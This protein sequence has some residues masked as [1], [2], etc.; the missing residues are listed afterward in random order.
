MKIKKLFK[1]GLF[2]S[3]SLVSL[4]FYGVLIGVL[5]ARKLGS[6][7]FGLY[8]VAL[9][10]LVF[11]GNTISNSLYLTLSN[12]LARKDTNKKRGLTAP[13]LLVLMYSLLSCLILIND[14]ISFL[15]LG[16]SD[17][18]FTASFTFA[19][20]SILLW[21]IM[22]AEH[23]TSGRLK[24][25]SLVNLAVVL[26]S[27]SVTFIY[28]ND[29]NYA[30]F[31]WGTPYFITSIIFIITSN[32]RVFDNFLNP[33]IFS[34]IFIIIK[35]TFPVIISSVIVPFTFYI[36]YI[37]VSKQENGMQTVALFASTMQ[38]TWIFS[39]ISLVMGGI[40][41]PHL[42]SSVTNE[43]KKYVDIFNLLVPW[44]LCSFLA[45][46]LI[47]FPEIHVLVYGDKFKGNDLNQV[48]A[49]VLVAT[50]INSFKAGL[51]RKFISAGISSISVYSNLLWAIIFLFM[52]FIQ[53]TIT[54]FTFGFLFLLSIT[55][56]LASLL[57]YLIKKN[58][59][60]F[61]FLTLK[62]TWVIILNCGLCSLIGLSFNSII[63]KVGFFVVILS[64]SIFLFKSFL[65]KEL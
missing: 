24:F 25:A 1:D 55:I 46:I 16:T 43:D 62:S 47:A 37:L 12:Y 54:P 5:I 33:S 35:E 32:N 50:I 8:S 2:N 58:V 31:F 28:L 3:I 30:F 20:L 49:F 17:K 63:Y 59:I 56:Q 51:S 29:V 48:I 40:L 61:E 4:K 19:G 13:M 36:A 41:I 65:E 64:S 26:I 11:S 44:A 6:D 7:T 15:V 53:K 18:S 45:S 22:Q 60:N 39:H 14:K 10:A 34:E 52:I 57:P 38:W 42:T 21:G 9:G 23:C 27:S